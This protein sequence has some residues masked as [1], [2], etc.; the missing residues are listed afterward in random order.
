MPNDDSKN[1]EERD[2]KWTSI[3]VRGNTH[4]TLK[5]MKRIKA[6]GKFE[7][8]DEVIRRGMGMPENKNDSEDQG[9]LK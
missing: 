1:T 9:D 7:N 2:K 5:S 4:D 8:F 3:A 6:P